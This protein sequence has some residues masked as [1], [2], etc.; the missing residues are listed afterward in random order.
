MS[1]EAKKPRERNP[2]SVEFDKLKGQMIRLWPND[3][4]DS[5]P[6]VGRLIWVAS[7]TIGVA[8]GDGTQGTEQ[9]VSMIFKQG[10]MRIDP[11]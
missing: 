2:E 10:G 9:R 5:E 11:M 3:E 7:H 8:F 6:C 4:W 1:G